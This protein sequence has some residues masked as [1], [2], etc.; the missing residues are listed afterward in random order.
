MSL[1]LLGLAMLV[2][3]LTACTSRITTV[4]APAELTDIVGQVAVELVWAQDIGSDT[5][6]LL[7]GLTPVTDGQTVY[8]AERDG[9]V[10]A[11]RLTDG[12]RVWR[13]KVERQTRGDVANMGPWRRLVTGL[14]ATGGARLAA[15]PSLADG[16][17]V[18]GSSDGEVAALSA[19][20]GSLRWSVVV[21][22]EVLSA[23]AIGGGLVVVR[24][25]AGALLALDV[26]DGSQRWQAEQPVPTLTLRGN[27]APVLEGGRVYVGFDNGK[28]AA[29]D[30]ARGTL[31]WESPLAQPAGRT[32]IDRL[33]D[34]DGVIRAARGELVAAGFNGRVALL[35]SDS[36]QPLWQR[37][38]SSSVGVED[39]GRQVY[40][41][42]ENSL[43]WAL[44]RRNGGTLWTQ[45]AL[46]A[47]QLTAP[48]RIGGYIA[49]A[50][51][52]GWVHLLDQAT[53]AQAARVRAG[54]GAVTSTPLVFQDLL[55]VQT[56]AGELY[57][58]RVGG[59]G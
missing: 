15:G 36:G 47:R 43:V 38:L 5:E 27:A 48:V 42:D 24:T 56:G 52:K 26:A 39:D 21:P 40:T 29:Y 49:V 6:G 58:F 32:E 51:L 31:V 22:G 11:W 45:D 10:S 30:L 7:L 55:V 17:L 57:A 33:V 59:A 8:V 14:S 46:R 44:D 53:G 34:V 25:A 4:E 35:A 54:G 2:S 13:T 16:L 12:R 50:D 41:T 3:A 28:L 19:A 1:R 23:P 20:D 37:D 9:F 18:V